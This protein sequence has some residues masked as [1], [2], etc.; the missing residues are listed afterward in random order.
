MTDCSSR[1]QSDIINFVCY[2]LAT[3]GSVLAA[4]LLLRVL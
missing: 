3:V 4:D 2:G 1:A